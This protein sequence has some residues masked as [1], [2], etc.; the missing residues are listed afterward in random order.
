MVSRVFLLAMLFAPLALAQNQ[1]PKMIE[2]IMNLD[3]TKA[4]PM[5]GKQY[6]GASFSTRKFAGGGE[7][8]GIKSARTKEFAT[9]EFLGIRNPWIGKKTHVTTSAPGIRSYAPG[10]KGFATRGVETRESPD[11]ARKDMQSGKAADTR[12]F[13]G[14]GK[15]QKALD[16]EYPQGSA[17]TIDEVRDLLNRNR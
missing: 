15:S 7:Y 10:D 2:R 6:E 1:E 14:R 12:R 3:R 11:A 4:N 9:R 16:A 13:L 17:M 8:A 5:G